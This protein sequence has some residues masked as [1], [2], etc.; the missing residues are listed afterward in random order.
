MSGCGSASHSG[1][2]RI[3]RQDSTVRIRSKGLTNSLKWPESGDLRIY[4]LNGKNTVLI[5]LRDK[6]NNWQSELR[7]GQP[8]LNNVRVSLDLKSL[9][10]G[11]S[12]AQIDLYNPWQNKWQNAKPE[13]LKIILPDFKRSLVIRIKK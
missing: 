5:W 12:F 2:W 13:D 8:P 4:Q 1:I 6:R 3:S 10:I 11:D 7:D 9:G